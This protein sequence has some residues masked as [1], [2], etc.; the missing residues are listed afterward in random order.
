MENKGKLSNFEILN[1]LGLNFF[2][3]IGSGAYSSVYK[4]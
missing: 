2:N 3:K 4:V 1:K